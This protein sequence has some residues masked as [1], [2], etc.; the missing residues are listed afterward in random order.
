MTEFNS[1]LDLVFVEYEKAFDRVS[2]ESIWHALEQKSHSTKA[3]S[4]D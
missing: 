3:G 4:Y 2:R 1:S